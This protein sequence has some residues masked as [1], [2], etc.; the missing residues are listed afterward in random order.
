MA[1]HTVLLLEDDPATRE[2]LQGIVCSA[3]GLQ[4]LAAFGDVQS[5]LAWLA[6]NPAPQVLLSDLQ[7]PDGSG[8]EVIRHL[9]RLSPQTESMVISVFGDEAHVV[10]AIEAGATGYLLK[11]ADADEIRSAILRL[12]AG[13]SPISSAIARHLL[14]RFQPQPEPAATASSLTPREREVLQ[15]IAKGLSYN[16][17][18]EALQMS[19]NTVTSHIKQIYRKLAVNSRGEAVF[20]AQQLGWLNAPRP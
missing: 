20:E 8:I 1:S 4:L 11:D 14:R 18:A 6:Q 17:I 12:V 15:L 19:P 5:T 9:R 7:L 13:E 10:A 2:R 3:D 16:R